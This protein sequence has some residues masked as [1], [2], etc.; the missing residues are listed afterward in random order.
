[1]NRHPDRLKRS[2]SAKEFSPVKVHPEL[3][4]VTIKAQVMCTERGES[5]GAGRQQGEGDQLRYFP[6]IHEVK[7]PHRVAGVTRP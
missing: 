4:M 2:I 1:M 7:R 6:V 5:T 3:M